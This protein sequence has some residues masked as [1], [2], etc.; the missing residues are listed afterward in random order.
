[1]ITIL[2][3]ETP[4]QIAQVRDLLT[5]YVTFIRTDIDNH[6]ADPLNAAPMAGYDEE[7]AALPGVYQPPSGRLL[8]ALAD[9]VPVGCVGLR[10][11]QGTVGEVKRLWVR[12]SA[13]GL[14]VGRAL[15]T[16]LIAEARGAGYTRLILSTADKL[17]QAHALYASLGFELTEPYFE[18]P[19][20]LM[21]H[22]LFMRLDLPPTPGP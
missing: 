9:G 8:L 16:M 6:L 2:Q 17:T 14:G 1:M 5:E 10:P 20:E 12:P 13:R 19:E 22:E 7:M 15:A 21:A 4:E 11:Y 18:G 3:V